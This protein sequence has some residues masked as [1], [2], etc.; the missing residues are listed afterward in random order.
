MGKELNPKR[1]VR[2]RETSAKHEDIPFSKKTSLLAGVRKKYETFDEIA[3]LTWV[4]LYRLP[5]P[6]GVTQ[7]RQESIPVERN[8][9]G[10]KRLLR[11]RRFI[12]DGSHSKRR[13]LVL[14]DIQQ[15]L[16]S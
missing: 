1:H 7:V 13:K 12:P 11:S 9:P 5:K 2:R 15:V 6:N 14:S 3:I 4:F 16:R 8:H 10:Q